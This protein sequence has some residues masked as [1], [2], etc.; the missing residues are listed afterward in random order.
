MINKMGELWIVDRDASD[1]CEWVEKC[2]NLCLFV[3]GNYSFLGFVNL[4]RESIIREIYF[5]KKVSRF[6]MK[7]FGRVRETNGS[8]IYLVVNF[9]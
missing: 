4:F 2:L 6:F 3:M 1:T 7:S 9:L 5:C 8:R